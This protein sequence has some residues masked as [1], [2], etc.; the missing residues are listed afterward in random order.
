MIVK[1]KS[2]VKQGLNMAM[3]SRQRNMLILAALP[4][5]QILLKSIGKSI[6]YLQIP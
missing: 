3:K 5:I 4:I 6:G 1:K 2:A